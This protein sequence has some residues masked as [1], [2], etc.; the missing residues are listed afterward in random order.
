M[1][2][3]GSQ[4]IGT[5]YDPA[6]HWAGIVG[7]IIGLLALTTTLIAVLRWVFVPH[8][9]VA[10][11]EEFEPIVAPLRAEVSEVRSDVT[12]LRAEVTDLDKTLRSHMDEES[13]ELS[14]IRTWRA[15]A[16][17]ALRNIQQ[18][19]VP[20]SDPPGTPRRRK[21]DRPKEGTP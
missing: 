8:I 3:R 15:S 9:R 13:G 7:L 5:D 6:V 14:D 19:T 17:I 21:T 11:R 4:V 2:C 10:I 12:D 20:A 1:G 16:D 18:A